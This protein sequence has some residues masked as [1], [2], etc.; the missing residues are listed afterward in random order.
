MRNC[1]AC[2]LLAV[3]LG[4]GLA[5]AGETGDFN[6]TVEQFGAH[7]R[8]AVGYLRTGNSDLASLE[9]D[10]MRD[11]WKGVAS[12][13]G[14]P[15]DGYAA[16]PQLYT[17][18]MLEVSTRLV[19]A[20]IMTSSGR[21][22]AARDVL[23]SIRDVLSDLRKA[24][25]IYLLADCVRDANAAMDAL[26]VYNDRALDWSKSET[27]FN[28]AAKASIYGYTLERCDGMAADEVRRNEEFRRLIDGA[29]AGLALVPKA[30]NTRDGELL[31][32]IL[33]ELRSFDNLLAFRYG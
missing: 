28:V 6:A 10:R 9:M 8:V 27:R 32:R 18:T 30:V 4:F 33:I 3:L 23:L 1:L 14:K 29:K 16:D 21:Q 7:N 26:Y 17:T 11:A 15:P 12:R 22:D 25:S 13:F 2:G 19:T 31:H 24:N 5:R 20:T